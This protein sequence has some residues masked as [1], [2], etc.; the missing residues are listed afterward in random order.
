VKEGTFPKDS[1]VIRLDQPYRNLV[2]NLLGIQ[3]YPKDAPQS[4]DD[5][6]WTLGL[7]MD[8]ETKEIND[9]AIFEAPLLPLT[10]PV[11]AKGGVAGGKAE[12][13]YIINNGT[14][15]KL[16]PARLK[17]KDFKALAA[18]APFKVDEKSFEAGSMII[19]VAKAQARIHQAVESV[20]SEFGLEVFASAKMPDVKSHDLDIPR[21]AI[22]HTWMSAQDD[23]WVRFAFDQMGIPFAMINK[24]HLRK[25]NLKLLYDVIVFSNCRGRKGADIVSELDPAER[26]LLSFVKS[27]EFKHLGTPDSSEDITGGMGLEGVTNL[28]KFAEQGGLL[29]AL[30]NPVRVAVDY[31]LVRGIDIYNTSPAFYNPG[32]LLKAEV[33]NEKHPLCY[34]YGKEIAIYRSHSGPLLTIPQEKEKFVVLRYAK[35]G[36]VCLSG[37]VKND[38]E[39]KGKAAV[40]DMPVGKG[41]IVMFTFNPFWRDLSHGSYMFVFNAI[42]NYNDLDAG[43]K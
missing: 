21:I 7:N 18:E 31:G 15:N 17:L 30:Q 37:I 10:K 12:S 26:G 28:Q 5:T 32:S 25:G 36:D 3:K 43:F 14:I 34:G 27:K 11:E 13:C 41:H 19:P 4:Y 20:A 23:G 9:K 42:L 1:Y 40:V 2:L 29:I 33:I 6:G 8:I 24:D 39:I 22:F 35:E 38:S 16:L